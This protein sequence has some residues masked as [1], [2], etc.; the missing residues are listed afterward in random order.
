MMK[1]TEAIT[2]EEIDQA[3]RRFRLDGGIIKKVPD[4]C[5]PVCR[6]VGARHGTCMDLV[7]R[8]W[9]LRV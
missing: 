6:L 2:Q 5:A 4:E 9:K 8:H 1:R 7:P 3:L